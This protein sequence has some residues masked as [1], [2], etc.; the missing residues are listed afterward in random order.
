[1]LGRSS[2]RLRRFLR[3]LLRQLAVI[4]ITLAAIELVLRVADL[5][6]LRDGARPGY[7]FVY[8]YDA[9]L[10][11][12]PVPNASSEFTGSRCLPVS[13]CSVRKGDTPGVQCGKYKCRTGETCV[14][15]DGQLRCR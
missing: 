6:F 11:W 15:Q 3:E 13:G 9:D 4:L 5:R 2:G 12:A 10:G 1:M 8:R 14:R 7:A